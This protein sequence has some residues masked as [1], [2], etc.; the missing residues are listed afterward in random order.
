VSTIDKLLALESIL[1]D[2]QKQPDSSAKDSLIN[3]ITSNVVRVASSKDSEKHLLLLVG[4]IAM[5][6]AS[7]SNTALQ[8]ARKLA[9]IVPSKN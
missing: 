6:S 4:A 5:L 1:E 3:Y 9:N 8:A 7:N 2:V